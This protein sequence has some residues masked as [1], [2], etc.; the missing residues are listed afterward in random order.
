[1]IKSCPPR[2]IINHDRSSRTSVITS[3]D[4]PKS[5]LPSGIPNLEF[6]FLA[7]DFDNPGSVFYTDCVRTISHEFLVDELSHET[8]FSD[9]HVADDDVLENVVVVVWTGGRHG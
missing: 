6:D 5:F 8:R 1:M 2:D 7:L 4:R 3:C 9:A